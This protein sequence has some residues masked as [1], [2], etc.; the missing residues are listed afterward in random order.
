VDK[1]KKDRLGQRAYEA[2]KKHPILNN[3][4]IVAFVITPVLIVLLAVLL[5]VFK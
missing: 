1:N 5:I 3:P 4:I 2:E